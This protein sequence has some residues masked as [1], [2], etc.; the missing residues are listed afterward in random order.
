M[1]KK[2]NQ[3]YDFSFKLVLKNLLVFVKTAS[4][5]HS[6]YGQIKP[7]YSKMKKRLVS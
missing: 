4:K 2:P 5:Q 3:L 7:K 1:F 6:R